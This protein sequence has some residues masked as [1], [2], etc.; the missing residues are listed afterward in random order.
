MHIFGL[1][2]SRTGTTSLNAALEQLGYRAKHYPSTRWWLGGVLIGLKRDRLDRY[3][4][5][6]DIPVIPLYKRLDRWSPGS[7]FVLTERNIDDWLDSCERYHRFGPAFVMGRRARLIRKAVYGT[8]TFDR[9]AFR[10]AYH[11]HSQDVLGYF[12][13]RPADLLRMD[14]T[15]GDGW[16]KLCPFLGKPLPPGPFPSLNVHVRGGQ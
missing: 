14:I 12:A 4:A 16:E 11:R 9:V 2:L 5:F 8:A 3:D 10:E 6:T 7:K 15:A 13:D 1:G